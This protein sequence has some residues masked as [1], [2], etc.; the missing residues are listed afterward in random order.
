MRRLDGIAIA[1]ARHQA[2]LHLAGGREV[3]REPDPDRQQ[4][5]GDNEPGERAAPV[6]AIAMSI[7]ERLP[8]GA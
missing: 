2:V 7:I 6:I 8:A 3:A 1:A 5:N 4:H